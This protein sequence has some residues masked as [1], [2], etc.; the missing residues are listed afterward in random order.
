M[1]NT[2]SHEVIVLN[3]DCTPVYNVIGT[4]F[5]G[6]N[7]IYISNDDNDKLK[8]YVLI[9]GEVY[10]YSIGNPGSGVNQIVIEGYLIPTTSVS[11]QLKFADHFLCGTE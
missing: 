1:Q 6:Q 3:H 2:I 4:G 8:A 11:I 9:D 10:K 5:S 7:I